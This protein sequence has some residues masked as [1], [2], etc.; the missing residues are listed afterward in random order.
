MEKKLEEVINRLEA[1]KKEVTELEAVVA[2]LSAAQAAQAPAA[3]G[4]EAVA[5][6]EPFGDEEPVDLSEPID[7]SLEEADFVPVPAGEPAV[8]IEEVPAAEPMA[9]PVAE[10]EAV[11]LDEVEDLP[12]E[13]LVEPEPAEEPEP[14]EKPEPVKEPESVEKP[15][16][17]KE[18]EP[19]EEPKAE[20]EPASEEGGF[21]DLFGEE[22]PAEPRKGRRRRESI[23]EVAEG[24]G[25]KAVVDAMEVGAAWRTDIPGPEVKSLRS[26]IALGDQ[27]MFI[28]R[29]FRKDSALYQDT[30]DRLNR[31]GTLKEAIAYLSETFPEWDLASD[32]V[33][34][35]MM[36]VRRKIRK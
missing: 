18:P 7:I 14:V 35:F 21:F 19:A 11:S 29:L 9:E 6:V 23:A 32:D 8:D 26:A 22:I 17:V 28:S 16:P 25:S 13:P 36:A 4:V 2:E 31:T 34:K 1:L 15:E 12:E 24:S 30:V 10:E 20:A 27:V 33:Y 5:P 3:A